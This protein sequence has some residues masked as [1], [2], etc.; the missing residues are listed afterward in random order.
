ME[1][2]RSWSGLPKCIL[3]LRS[4][5]ERPSGSVA[6]AQTS[7]LCRNTMHILILPCFH[8]QF[9]NTSVEQSTEV[10]IPEEGLFSALRF[11]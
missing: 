7:N 10:E 3:N 5:L 6:E 2:N 1:G 8:I 4:S 11:A 9:Y